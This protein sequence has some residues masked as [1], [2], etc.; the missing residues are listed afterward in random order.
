MRGSQAYKT[1]PCILLLRKHLQLTFS[2]ESLDFTCL[3][4]KGATVQI[5]ACQIH[6]SDPLKGKV[7]HLE[8]VGAPSHLRLRQT[9]SLS[10]YPTQSNTAVISHTI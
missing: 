10:T 9:H 7:L 5:K 4:G 3:F 6:D 1:A 2:P 8:T